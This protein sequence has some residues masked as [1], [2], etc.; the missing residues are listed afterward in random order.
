M[1]GQ[2]IDEREIEQPS[3]STEPRLESDRDN[4]HFSHFFG[5]VDV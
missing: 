5:G 2:E 4:S 3:S 1:N